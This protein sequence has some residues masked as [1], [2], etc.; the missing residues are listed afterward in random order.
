[1]TRTISPAWRF[2]F[3]LFHLLLV[4]SV[5]IYS[6]LHRN[7]NSSARYWTRLQRRCEYRSTGRDSP[8]GGPTGRVFIVKSMD[9][10]RGSG[11]S[12]SDRMVVMGRALTIAVTSAISVTKSSC[13]SCDPPSS[14]NMSSNTQR[15]V[16]I[17]RSHAPPNCEAY[18]GLKRHS[19]P[20]S[21][22][23][24][25]NLRWSI[26][27]IVSS[28]SDFPPMKLVPRSLLSSDAGPRSAKKRLS[29]Q[30]KELVSMDS[31]TSMWTALLL[32]QVRKRPQRLEPVVP[33]LV[34]RV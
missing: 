16:P 33:P 8:G 12:V 31:K 5:W 9:G 6:R 4:C 14:K 3:E 13:V 27:F 17:C 24:R 7:Q 1:M 18:G 26:S 29:A 25:S 19:Q 10:E 23:Y 2:R 32:R 15:M 20:S 21:L 28:S 11:S 22:T 30:M 34:F